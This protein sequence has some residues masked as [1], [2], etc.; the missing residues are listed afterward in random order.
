MWF[1]IN[2]EEIFFPESIKLF[3]QKISNL[4]IFFWNK[5]FFLF[6]F[7]STFF[8]NSHFKL[9]FFI[10]TFYFVSYSQRFFSHSISTQVQIPT[11]KENSPH[12]S[13]KKRKHKSLF[14]FIRTG[15]NVMNV[16][17]LVNN[18]LFHASQTPTTSFPL[19]EQFYVTSR[20]FLPRGHFIRFLLF[21]SLRSHNKHNWFPQS[22]P[23]S[24]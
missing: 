5:I 24:V 15:Q 21:I 18:L 2:F 8:I 7:F 22:L 20:T 13:Y 19:L 3:Q 17:F 10:S 12:K 16:F 4:Q 14:M 23:I 6:Q 9:F 11:K 1:Q